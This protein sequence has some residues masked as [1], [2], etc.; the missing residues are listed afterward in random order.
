M[1]EPTTNVDAH[2]IPARSTLGPVDADTRPRRP[3][4]LTPDEGT[5]EFEP[6]A[7]VAMALRLPRGV[8]TPSEFWSMLINKEDGRCE[9]SAS[10]YNIHYDQWFLTVLIHS[11][12]GGVGLAS[13]RV[14][15]QLKAKIFATVGNKEKA[16]YLVD[17]TSIPRDCI[18]NSRD[19]SFLPDVMR[20]TG[21]RG[22]DVVLNSLAGKLLHASWEKFFE[23]GK[24]DLLTHGSLDM[25]LFQQN[26]AFY[27]VDLKDLA[28]VNWDRFE[29][30]AKIAPI[31]PRRVFDAVDIVE[32]FRYMQTGTHIGKIV[33]RMPDS[34]DIWYRNTKHIQEDLQSDVVY[35]LV[36]GLGGLGRAIA[37]WMWERGA[38]HFVFMSRSAGPGDVADS[39][40]VQRALTHCAGRL[41]AGVLQLSMVL[42]VRAAT[43]PNHTQYNHAKTTMWDKTFRDMP[44]SD[45]TTALAPKVQGTWNLHEALQG[46]D[47]DFFVLFGSSISVTGNFGQ[48]NYAATNSFLE[49]FA[50]YRRQQGLACSVVHLGPVEDIGMEVMEALEL[51]IMQPPVRKGTTT[52]RN[53]HEHEN[54]DAYSTIVG[55]NTSKPTTDPNVVPIWQGDARFGI[56]YGMETQGEQR[57][58]VYKDRVKLLVGRIEADASLL[59]EPE[60][61]RELTL[62]LDGIM[63]DYMPST[64][65]A[66]MSE[67]QVGSI[68]IDSLMAIEIKSKVWDGNA[69]AS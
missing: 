37:T 12:C 48:A 16:Q 52:Q 39:Q 30:D 18:F 36:G 6:I 46:S 58:S 54:D 57:A 7:I 61:G 45:W 34:A 27:D 51:A 35:L 1:V 64:A 49:A 50:G 4:Q 43:P 5:V 63:T 20:A 23:I 28:E 40:D 59:D 26:R 68:S 29:E 31:E 55:L 32:A 19:A 9:I 15:Q 25:S 62:E 8:S 42:R 65:A 60:F 21:G 66:D 17:N 41:L 33:V 56:Y 69:V 22:V 38:R 11:L 2:Q 3:H 44:F 53:K 14:C 24:R 10:R 67:E 13:I 47:V